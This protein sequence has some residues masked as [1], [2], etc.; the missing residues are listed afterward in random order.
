MLCL[1][2]QLVIRGRRVGGVLNIDYPLVCSWSSF[3]GFPLEASCLW[4][5]RTATRLY[6]PSNWCG[7]SSV[8]FSKE[9]LGQCFGYRSSLRRGGCA[10]WSGTGVIVSDSLWWDGMRG[11]VRYFART[12]LFMGS[13]C[14]LMF[15]FVFVSYHMPQIKFEYNT[16]FHLL[17]RCQ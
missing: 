14:V 17:R 9:L 6:D 7:I 2:R 10:H 15:P 13:D 12:L 4:D 11:I 1:L 8:I 3:L 5:V 16:P